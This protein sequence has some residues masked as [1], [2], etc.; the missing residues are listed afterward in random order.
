MHTH[1]SNAYIHIHI[2]KSKWFMS[3]VNI[4]QPFEPKIIFIKIDNYIANVACMPNSWHE[5]IISNVFLPHPF[6]PYFIEF[7]VKHLKLPDEN[8]SAHHHQTVNVRT[9]FDRFGIHSIV[10]LFNLLLSAFGFQLI[11]KNPFNRQQN[12]KIQ[13]DKTAP[14]LFAFPFRYGQYEVSDEPTAV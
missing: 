13:N 9:I 10:K 11:E 12:Y 1:E 2:L 8:A 7:N 6:Q 5:R 4:S 14:L 3:C